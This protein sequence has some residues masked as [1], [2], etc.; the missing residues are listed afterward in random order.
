MEEGEEVERSQQVPEAQP[1]YSEPG[2]QPGYRPDGPHYLRN[3]DMAH[4]PSQY[5]R[6]SG[7]DS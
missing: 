5:C 2:R 6:S 4:G 3:A 1:Q 7:R